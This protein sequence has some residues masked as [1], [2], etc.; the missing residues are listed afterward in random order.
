[1][2]EEDDINR[3]YAMRDKIL[4]DK[5]KGDVDQMDEEQIQDIIANFKRGMKKQNQLTLN[6]LRHFEWLFSDDLKQK[7][8]NKTLTAA[9]Q[10][11]YEELSLEFRSK[12]NFY[13]PITIVDDITG[14]EAM[15]PL[16]PINR[17]L[18]RASNEAERQLIEAFNSAHQLDDGNPNGIIAAHQAQ[19]TKMVMDMIV[20]NNLKDEL[21]HEQDQYIEMSRRVLDAVHQGQQPK[22]AQQ[23]VTTTDD[24]DEGFDFD[25]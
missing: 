6:E 23:R 12:I 2:S 15:P 25:L 4:A 9:E 7:L 17:R 8:A 10:E 1:M 24:P 21:H 5:L 14:E 3:R 19:T 22:T 20:A 11:R 18:T 16:P 13:L